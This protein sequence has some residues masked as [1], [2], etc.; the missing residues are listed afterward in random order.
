MSYTGPSSLNCGVCRIRKYIFSEPHYE[1]EET[2]L[3]LCVIN[4]Y[5]FLCDNNVGDKYDN[6]ALDIE[7]YVSYIL[8]F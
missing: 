3:N 5:I 8:Y 1:S 4:I 2:K 7:T 6:I